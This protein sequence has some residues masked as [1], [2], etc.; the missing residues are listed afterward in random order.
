MYWWGQRATLAPEKMEQ[1]RP[2]ARVTDAKDAA[3][4]G[5]VRTKATVS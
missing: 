5:V 2:H 3:D 4:E 1:A